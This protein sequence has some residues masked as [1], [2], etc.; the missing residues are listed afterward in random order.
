MKSLFSLFFLIFGTLLFVSCGKR[1]VPS[2][3]TVGVYDLDLVSIKVEGTVL[4]DGGSPILSRGFCFGTENNPQ[5]TNN[6][7]W[8]STHALNFTLTLKNLLPN[9]KYYVCAFSKNEFGISY[10][11]SLSFTTETTYKIGDT[12]PG[13]GVVFYSKEN[14]DG[15]WHYLECSLFDNIDMPWI[16]G[17]TLTSIST[18]L[19]IGDGMTNTDTIVSFYGISQFYA[20]GVSK[21]IDNGFSDWFLP[22]L[23]ELILMKTNLS[24]VGLANFNASGIYWSSSEDDNYFQNVWTVNMDSTAMNPICTRSK[25]LLYSVRKIRRF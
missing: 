4:N 18:D 22:S 21:L 20:A 13:G 5:I 2:I 16:F 24:N 3:K 7:I 10:G 15:G 19:E 9:T 12:G 11:K 25:L 6:V 23:K 14:T 1:T 17:D 8:D